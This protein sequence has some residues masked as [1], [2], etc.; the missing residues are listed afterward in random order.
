[1][2]KLILFAVFASFATASF[3][4]NRTTLDY[5]TTPKW[6]TNEFAADGLSSATKVFSNTATTTTYVY[7]D[8]G[9]V[10]EYVYQ[11]YLSDNVETTFNVSKVGNVQYGE[12]IV[13][14]QNNTNEVSNYLILKLTETE[15]HLIYFPKPGE[16]RIG[17]SPTKYYATPK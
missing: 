3:A 2:K 9:Y 7:A 1:M 12:Y 14:R 11:F 13:A 5:L 10:K 4:Q 6:K 15:L 8:D 17:I 16:K